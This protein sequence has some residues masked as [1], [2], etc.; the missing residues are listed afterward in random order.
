MVNEIAAIVVLYNPNKTV[1]DNIKSYDKYM[2]KIYL[3]DNSE[4]LSVWFIS[5]LK[6]SI[7]MSKVEYY[8]FGQNKGIAAALNEGMKRAI[9]DKY[10]WIL[11]MDQDSSF[12]SDIIKEY[13]KCLDIYDNSKI[14]LISPQ[15][16]SNRNRLKKYKND[17]LELYWTM[18]SANLINADNYKKVGKFM[19]ELF[20]D[21]VDYEY[22]LRCRK[23]RLKILRCNN[24][25][26][27]HC[28]ATT[29][30]IR[31]FIWTL[32]YGVAP[33]IRIYY[34]VRNALYM[35]E[36]YHNLKSLQIIFIK[37]LKIIFLFQEKTRY[38]KAF[39]DAF[40][41]YKNKNYGQKK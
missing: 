14:A 17:Y 1:I 18:Q 29:S 27:N 15:Y 9:Q 11:T 6:N 8:R 2:E 30:E 37:L 34:Q 26:L 7:D 32:K 36:K 31:I 5:Q 38:F 39:K 20:I 35:F 24:A 40:K 28:P 25:I 33:P 22:C 19:E 41:D 4:E 23:K 16:V 10:N 12:G 13:K 3:I 21:C